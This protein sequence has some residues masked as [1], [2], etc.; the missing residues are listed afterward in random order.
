MPKTTYSAHYIADPGFRRAVEAYLV[1]ERREIA[2]Q[3]E[4]LAER[5]PFRRGGVDEHDGP[6]W[7]LTQEIAGERE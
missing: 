6:S 3:G 4:A 2:F 1:Q 7:D 5:A